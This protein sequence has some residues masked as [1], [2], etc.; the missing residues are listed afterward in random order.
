MLFE[1]QTLKKPVILNFLFQNSHCFF[2]IVIKNF[3]F[4]FLQVYRPFLLIVVD[5][6]LSPL[7]VIE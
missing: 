3:D 2:H 4:D 1:F 7:S 5:G 6:Y